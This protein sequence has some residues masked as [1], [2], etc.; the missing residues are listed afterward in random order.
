MRSVYMMTIY[1]QQLNVASQLI[2]NGHAWLQ[3]SFANNNQYS[4]YI[5]TL[6]L[7]FSSKGELA[8][9]V[10]KALIILTTLKILN[11]IIYWL[12]AMHGL[13]SSHAKIIASGCSASS[14]KRHPQ[15]NIAGC[16]VTF[17]PNILN[18]ME[19]LDC[20]RIYLNNVPF[21]PDILHR[22]I[23][24]SQ[25]CVYIYHCSY[26]THDAIKSTSSASNLQWL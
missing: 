10:F 12:I 4:P 21:H 19:Q 23:S 9:Q 16:N 15:L 17:E 13:Y 8:S 22:S 24:A 6:K 11:T 5:S 25:V 2:Q 3:I 20:I 7:G 1:N 14:H 26:G 18:S